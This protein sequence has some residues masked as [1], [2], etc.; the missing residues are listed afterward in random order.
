MSIDKIICVGKNYLEHAKELGDEIPQKPVLFLKPAS[1]LLQ[2]LNWET[3][4]KASFPEA[5]NAV[6]PECEIVLRVAY[7]AYRITVEEAK[8]NISDLAIGLDMTLRNHQSVLKKQ[9]HPWTTAK[10]FKDAAIISPWIP[11]STFN[12]YLDI[13]F[14]LELNGKISQ[15]AKGRDMM[16]QPF[17]LLAYISQFFPIK[18]GDIIFTGTPAGVSSI[19]KGTKAK[20]IWGNYCQPVSWF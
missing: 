9:G 16:M 5:D 14:Q 4:V 13:E 7:D 19:S 11:I 15:S 2:S 17:D 12:N 6:Q 20:L 8:N 10:V 18:A 3:N 1:V